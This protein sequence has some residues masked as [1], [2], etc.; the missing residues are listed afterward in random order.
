MMSYRLKTARGPKLV[1]EEKP[2]IV[3][4]DPDAGYEWN[5]LIEKLRQDVPPDL[6]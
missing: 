6:W 2:D 3:V 4:T 1:Q 5:E